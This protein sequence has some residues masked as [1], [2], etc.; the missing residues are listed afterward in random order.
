MF[1]CPWK[2]TAWENTWM[3]WTAVGRLSCG[4]T[5]EVIAVIYFIVGKNGNTFVEGTSCLWLLP[6]LFLKSYHKSYCKVDGGLMKFHVKGLVECLEDRRT[7]IAVF[8]ALHHFQISTFGLAT[9]PRKCVMVGKEQLWGMP[10]QSIWTRLL[11]QYLINTEG[12]YLTVLKPLDLKL[13]QPWN[14]YSTVDP[15]YVI[16]GVHALQ[17]SYDYGQLVQENTLDRHGR[18]VRRNTRDQIGYW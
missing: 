4:D 16:V 2:W 7:W 3:R 15:C 9:I 5:T 11:W 8:V 6:I 18:L 12:H 13:V 1:G 17:K 10:H 14:C